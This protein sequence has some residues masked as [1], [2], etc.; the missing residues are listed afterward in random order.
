ML[1]IL[2]N[3]KLWINLDQ[4]N[5]DP[6]GNLDDGLPAHLEFI[7]SIETPEGNKNV[8]LRRYSDSAGNYMWYFSADT[9][10]EI[11]YLYSL[12]GYGHLGDLLSDFFG[13]ISIWGIQIWQII[14]I[15]LLFIVGYIIS[16]IFTSLIAKFSFGVVNKAYKTN[17]NSYHCKFWNRNSF[18]RGFSQS[19]TKD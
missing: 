6:K 14:G 4:L 13:D 19:I 11:P 7:S 15:L 9:V 17:F 2:I 3:Q 18:S 1:R 12:Y 5:I 8:Y 10:R 16:F